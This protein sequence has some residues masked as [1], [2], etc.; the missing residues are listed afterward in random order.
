[1]GRRDILDEASLALD[2]ERRDAIDRI[3][4]RCKRDGVTTASDIIDAILR[5]LSTEMSALVEVELDPIGGA[6]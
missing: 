3:H 2:D 4:A 1:M 6:P 5:D